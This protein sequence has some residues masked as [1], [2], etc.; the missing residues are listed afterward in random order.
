M[1][2]NMVN[3]GHMANS[4]WNLTEV[5]ARLSKPA[6]ETRTTFGSKRQFGFWLM[7]AA[8]AFLVFGLFEVRRVPAHHDT[9]LLWLGIIA[10]LVMLFSQLMLKPS[11]R[12]PEITPQL[13]G[14]IQS[15]VIHPSSTRYFAGERVLETEILLKVSVDNLSSLPAKVVQW[16][17]RVEIAGK[18]YHVQGPLYLAEN[19]FGPPERKW[20]RVESMHEQRSWP[21]EMASWCDVIREKPV[22]GWL[23]FF[24]QGASAVDLENAKLTLQMMDSAGQLYQAYPQS[25]RLAA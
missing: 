23:A 9:L 7:S 14:E 3:G 6:R 1:H 15:Q 25:T 24:V 16:I 10:V 17:L 11:A 13:I 12:G 19:A 18:A 21:D 22:V 5:S 8:L 20:K 4:M 2:Q